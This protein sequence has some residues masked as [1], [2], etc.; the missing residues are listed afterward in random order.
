LV[1]Y[2]PKQFPKGGN[3][4]MNACRITRVGTMLDSIIDHKTPG[5]AEKIFE[6]EKE[7]LK[8]D[9][10]NVWN[11]WKDDNME[12]ILEVDSRKFGIAITEL[13]NQD[14]ETITTFTFYASVEHLNEKF[15]KK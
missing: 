10:P 4:E 8:L 5:H 6:A 15:K 1:V 9:I 13:T 12:R 7:I 11:V 2:F 3:R 14:I